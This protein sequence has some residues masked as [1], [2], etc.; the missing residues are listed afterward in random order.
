SASAGTPRRLR[1]PLP[2]ARLRLGRSRSLSTTLMDRRNCPA[3]RQTLS[4]PRSRRQT[5][6]RTEEL[7]LSRETEAVRSP[8]PR[9]LPRPCDDRSR[10]HGLQGVWSMVAKRR[11]RRHRAARDHHAATRAPALGT[12]LGARL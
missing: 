12:A 1:S 3:E 10:C 4:Q 9:E 2:L 7:T 8:T 6:A 11:V 5:P